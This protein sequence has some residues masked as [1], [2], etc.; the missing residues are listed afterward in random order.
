MRR[1]KKTKTIGLLHLLTCFKKTIKRLNI[2]ISVKQRVVYLV[3][4][5]NRL[6]FWMYLEKRK[7][8]FLMKKTFQG[9]WKYYIAKASL[10]KQAEAI[11]W[12][13]R[14][15]LRLHKALYPC[16]WLDHSAILT[17]LCIYDY[18]NF[19]RQNTGLFVQAGPLGEFVHIR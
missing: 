1:K 4:V 3:T 19:W 8:Y 6:H 15:K 9:L 10:P 14:S 16:L 5:S 2:P 17:T 18:C 11:L 13:Q 7:T 12:K